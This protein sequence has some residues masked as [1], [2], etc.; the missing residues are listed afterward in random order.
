MKTINIGVIAMFILTL[1][2]CKTNTDKEKVSKDSEVTTKVLDPMDSFEV[3]AEMDLSPGNVAVSK[4]GRMFASIHPLRRGNLQ[5]VE[6]TG[7]TTYVP[8]PNAEMQ[9]TPETVSNE[10]FDAPLG[11]VFDNRNRLWMVDVGLV[12]GQTRVFA[13][14]IDTKE[15]LYRFDVPK[16][17]ASAGSFIQ[18][19]AID[20]DNGFVYIADALVAGIVVI[21]INN[22]T[23]R[24]I[25]DMPSMGS[26][27][28]D[29]I[30]DGE[31]QYFMGEPFRIAIDPITLSKDRETLYYGAMN[32]TKYYK[33]P[34]KSIREGANDD[35][36]I[37]Q[38]AVAGEK[39]L[40]D[41][42]ATDDNDNHYFTNVQ[43]HSIDVLTAEGELKTLVKHPYFDWPDSVRIHEDW[44]YVA[45]NQTNK[46]ASVTGKEDKGVKPY[47]VVRFKYR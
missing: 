2:A 39:P 16:E 37:N 3:V 20:E 1:F 25:V 45:S 10:N 7:T 9:S 12:L 21:D 17:L 33:L 29:M 13:Y 8:F 34:T 47:R 15:E 44:L 22:N 6:I 18:D 31:V 19:L 41:G 40:S 27:D 26:E 28:I 11:V 42:A 30:I 46:S 14:D 24:R 43:N 38:I 5:L 4:E 35:I 36:I 23:F 32:G